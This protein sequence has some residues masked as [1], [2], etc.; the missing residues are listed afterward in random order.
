MRR[1]TSKWIDCN[2]LQ[3]NIKGILL[4][5]KQ[6]FAQIETSRAIFNIKLSK[7]SAKRLLES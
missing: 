1:K 2:D 3:I 5:K 6:A 4:T 7:S